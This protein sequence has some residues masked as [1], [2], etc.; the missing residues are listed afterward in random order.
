MHPLTTFANVD[1]PALGSFLA[2]D[3]SQLY[4]AGVLSVISVLPGDYN[5]DGIVDA[6]DY[7]VLARYARPNGR[8]R[9]R[10]RQRRQWHD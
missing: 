5:R 8:C 1:L 10:R 6:A 3:Q 7:T 9:H 4:I 2:W